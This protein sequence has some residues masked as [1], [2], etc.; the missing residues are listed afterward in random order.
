MDA[1]SSFYF[2]LQL[3]L[4]LLDFY[5]FLLNGLICLRYYFV[6]HLQEIK[7]QFVFSGIVICSLSLNLSVVGFLMDTFSWPKIWL[8]YENTL[9]PGWNLEDDDFENSWAWQ[10][11]K[12][13]RGSVLDVLIFTIISAFVPSKYCS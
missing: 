10:P 7:N 9:V 11:G 1:F 6:R 8:M 4:L 2:N 13:G 12:P 5:F 3:Y